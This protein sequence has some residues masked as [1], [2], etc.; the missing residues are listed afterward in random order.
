MLVSVEEAFHG[1][2][3]QARDAADGRHIISFTNLPATAKLLDCGE[4]GQDMTGQWDLFTFW[5]NF[6]YGS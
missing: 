6:N 5:D 3:I 2:V 4:H 1:F